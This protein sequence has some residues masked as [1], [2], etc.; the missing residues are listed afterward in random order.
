MKI[1][2]VTVCYEEKRSA[3]YQTAGFSAS[4]TATLE[5]GETLNAVIAKL[6]AGLIKVVT[7]TTMEQVNRLASEKLVSRPEETPRR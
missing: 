3:N 2:Q 4:V 1:D 5:D 7:E 6:K